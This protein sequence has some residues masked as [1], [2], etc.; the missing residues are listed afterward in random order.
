MKTLSAIIAHRNE[1]PNLADTVDSI[2]DTSPRSDVEIIVVDDA[3]D[4]PH[5]RGE[6]YRRLD[7]DQFIAEPERRGHSY[8]R[9]IGAE[10]AAGEWLLLTDAH[11]RLDSGWWE[12]LASNIG[13]DRISDGDLLCGP[14]LACNESGKLEG[15]FHGARFFFWEERDGKL[16]CV[17]I[18]PLPFEERPEIFEVPAVIGANY[19]LSRKHFQ[20]L[21][22]LRGLWGW[23]CC[24]E[25]LLS[26]KT[27]LTGGRVLLDPHF[28]L[29]HLLFPPAPA[30]KDSP[31]QMTKAEQIANRLSAAYQVLSESDWCAFVQNWPVPHTDPVMIEALRRFELVRD[32]L[33]QARPEYLPHDTDWLCAKFDLHHPADLGAVFAA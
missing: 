9:T 23:S 4:P 3:S 16:D 22:G 30:D 17:C 25:W 1:F 6:R 20:S 33:P 21:G 5:K 7:V 32:E 18:H 13:S 11:M 31:R 29:R 27:W 2:R 8:C 14:Y 26:V 10:H 24:D 28:R 12:R 15:T 19:V